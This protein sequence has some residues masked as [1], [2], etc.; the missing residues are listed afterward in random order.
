MNSSMSF[1]VKTISVFEKQAKRLIKKYPSLKKEIKTLVSEIKKEPTLGTPIGFD[2][3]KI[4]LSIASKSKGKSG[5]ARVITHLIYK[6]DAVYLLTIYD[7][8]EME[9]VSDKEIANF[10]KLIP[11]L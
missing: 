4:R 9:N 5:G 3:Y 1:K 10:L 6:E 2:C 7:K 8:S 11:Q